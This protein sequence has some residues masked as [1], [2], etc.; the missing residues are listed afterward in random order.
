MMLLDLCQNPAPSYNSSSS[1]FYHD[2]N[3]KA[4]GKILMIN[5]A[6]L[7]KEGHMDQHQLRNNITIE[8]EKMQEYIKNIWY[9]NFINIFVDKNQKNQQQTTATT[10]N[11]SNQITQS[12]SFYNSVATL[13]SNQVK[14]KFSFNS[15]IQNRLTTK[16]YFIF[17][18]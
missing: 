1:S 12:H 7:R 11:A 14:K 2:P 18:F 9:T 5:Y 3:H 17:I 13:A 6:K 8:L 4:I 10:K 16:F 15:I